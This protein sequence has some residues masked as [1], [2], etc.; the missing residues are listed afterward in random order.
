[1]SLGFCAIDF[2]TANSRRGSACYVRMTRV[3]GGAVLVEESF[4]MWPHSSLGRFSL[5]NIAV[6]GITP[7]MLHAAGAPC[8]VKP[9]AFSVVFTQ[10][11]RHLSSRIRHALT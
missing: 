11:F 8:W 4:L 9:N 2:E 10:E 6:R 3:H 1:M 5:G 7:D